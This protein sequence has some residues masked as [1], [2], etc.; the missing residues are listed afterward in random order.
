[1]FFGYYFAYCFVIILAAVLGIAS[2]SLA[3][4]IGK[5]KK[6]TSILVG[7]GTAFF[8]L[9]GIC[10]YY[11]AYL[12]HDYDH[13]GGDFDYYR[14][15]LDYPYELSTI[16]TIECANISKWQEDKLLVTGI[17]HYRK[18][19]NIIVGKISEECFLSDRTEWFSFDTKTG[20]V[21]R[22]DSEEEFRKALQALGFDEAPELLTIQENWSLYRSK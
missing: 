19:D 14:M 21:V 18:R 8:V 17:T 11:G 7:V 16:D 3:S 22:Y 9:L 13:Y 6:S 10:G 1:M 20:R 15:P 4:V 2:G 5:R 12:P